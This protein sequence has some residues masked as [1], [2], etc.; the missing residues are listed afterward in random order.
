VTPNDYAYLVY[1]WYGEPHPER[2]PEILATFRDCT[3][4]HRPGRDL[5]MAGALLGFETLYPD[6]KETWRS[7][8][9]A[10][11]RFAERA[12]QTDKQSPAWNDYYIAQWFIT[13][14]D[15]CLDSLLDRVAEGGEVGFETRLS[16]ENWSERCAPFRVNLE[17]AK[18]AR[19]ECMIIQ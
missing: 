7:E 8:F 6:K 15:K 19:K 17:R 3:W 18:A 13:R 16:L 11:Y 2:I 5:P 4:A 12:T 14:D 9:P 10:V 1:Y